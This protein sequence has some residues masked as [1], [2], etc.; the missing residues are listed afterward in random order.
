[1]GRS[2]ELRRAL[3]RLR[4]GARLLT[5]TGAA[6]IGKTALARRLIAEL[7]DALFCDLTEARD[8]ADLR[9]GVAAALGVPAPPAGEPG[10]QAL[11]RALGRGPGVLVL[12]N[13]EQIAEAAAAELDAWL[14]SSPTLQLVATSRAPLPA[15]SASRLH[16]GALAV[17]GNQ[18]SD[19][20]YLF[21]REATR[22][23]R[24]RG[25]GEDERVRVSAVVQRIGG[26]PLAIKLAAGRLGILDVASLL[27]RL[28]EGAD[29]LRAPHPEAGTRWS[30]TTEAIAWSW[31][32]LQPSE[33]EALARLSVF[34]GGFDASA[35]EDL[36]AATLS[37]GGPPPLEVVEALRD[38]SLVEVR[39]AP[40][41]RRLHLFLA[42]RAFAEARL[43]PA[44]RDDT[45]RWHARQVAERLEALER[46]ADGPEAAAVRDR[47]ADEWDNALAAADRCLA[48][49]DGPAIAVAL[50]VLAALRPLVLVRGPYEPY[51]ERLD[52][53][54]AC[55][56][57]GAHGVRI[58]ALL[59]RAQ[60][61]RG[62][63][64]GA[65]ALA[66]V[67]EA[68]ER[69]VAATDPR[70]EARALHGL[71]S[72]RYSLG[73]LDAARSLF[74][75][76]LAL[77]E[78]TDDEALVA[79]GARAVATVALETWA[80]DEAEAM[81][82][83]S[84]RAC[85]RG[86][87][88]RHEASA[89]LIQG[90]LCL[91]RGWLREAEDRFREACALQESL[92][93]RRDA[94]VTTGS[95]AIA[96]HLQG[97]LDEAMTLYERAI[98]ALESLGARRGLSLHF[99]AYRGLAELDAGRA[100]AA[101]ASLRRA[102]EGMRELG[103]AR[104][105]ALYGAWLACA[106]AAD[107]GYVEARVLLQRAR[108]LED[109]AASREIWGVCRRYVARSL[110]AEP[111]EPLVEAESRVRPVEVRLVLR[112]LRGA[113]APRAWVVDPRGR[114]FEAPGEARVDL[115]TRAAPSKILATLLDARLARPGDALSRNALF[116]AGWPDQRALP[117]A[118]AHRVY[119]AVS[120]LRKLGLR[121]VLR[122][123]GD[124]YLLDPEV[125][126]VAAS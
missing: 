101:R 25:L 21:V 55:S 93:S 125:P 103:D 56:D 104:H 64:R 35:A 5:L 61:A 48:A 81:L 85:R 70:L 9:A 28:D 52:A 86:R 106:H 78:E 18:P 11:G 126:V 116:E 47:M 119:V 30:S 65:E 111:D 4:D 100:S 121:A 24:G 3:A 123:V 94:A 118:A 92:G 74:E 102:H 49:G 27:A 60:I 31:R 8:V 73:E 63:G 72:L 71:G 36:L 69:A 87:L 16:L 40:S 97:R 84:L 109:D 66:D 88:T 67:E 29:V 14:E 32:L 38:R 13:L 112:L 19:A 107:G 26:N 22:V 59:A 62:L 12:D 1:M 7:D 58:R 20:C 82:E 115:R 99:H 57:R 113:Q 6:G 79:L 43:D 53:A 50:R 108:R 95:V 120:T 37:A 10:R 68:L 15:A 34:R 80:L 2:D 51:V 42:V 98:E 45:E 77:A 117:E 90:Q 41:G 124:G 46:R 33:R 96:S 122:R 105:E 114:W 89:R 44:A 54:L 76:G 110:G 17:D 75:R 23:R 83:R 39:T 91:H